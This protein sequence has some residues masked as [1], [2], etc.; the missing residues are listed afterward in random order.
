MPMTE[1]HLKVIQGGRD[2]DDLIVTMLH[3]LKLAEA[4]RSE[5]TYNLLRMAL[6]HEGIQI[7]KGM[8]R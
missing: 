5:T 2:T 4:C 6:L 3:A 7:A 8:E 1:H